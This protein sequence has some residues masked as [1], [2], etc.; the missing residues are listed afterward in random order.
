[1][2]DYSKDLFKAMSCKTPTKGSQFFIDDFADV[3][4]M[5]PQINKYGEE[6]LYKT[7]QGRIVLAPGGIQ[8]QPGMYLGEVM[9]G[10]HMYLTGMATHMGIDLRSLIFY[11]T[12]RV[13]K[14]VAKHNK[15]KRPL[16]GIR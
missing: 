1:M 3:W 5:V 11:I 6:S 16:L 7:Y 12:T 10:Y 15:K 4:V 14:V 2:I 13:S 9:S 8:Q